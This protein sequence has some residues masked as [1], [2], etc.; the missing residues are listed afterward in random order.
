M[1]PLTIPHLAGNEWQYIKDCLDT[2]WVSSAGS[3]V[4][5]FEDAMASYCSAPRAVA[6][7]N[8]TAGLHLA[9]QVAGV[10]PGERVILPNVT[11]V[12]SAN[13]ISYA[14]AQPL[15]VDIDRATWQMD[16]DLLEDFLEHQTEPSAEGLRIKDSGTLIR[17]VMPVHVLGNMCD[18]HRLMA[19]ADKHGLTVIEDS[20]ESL[21]SYFD[22]R[23][24][25]TFGRMGVFSFNGNKVITTGGGGMIVT[26]EQETADRLKHLS[27]Q[28]KVDPE[29]YFHDTVGYNYRLV[30]VLAAMGVA[31]MEQL[32]GF[33]E[34]KQQIDGFYRAALAGIG[35]I[36]FQHIPNKVAPNHWLFTIWTSRA[37]AVLK[38]LAA[39]Q[40]GARPLWVPMNQLPMYADAPYV[41]NGDVSQEVY[42]GSVSL[43][44]SVGIGEKDL[45]RVVKVI[46][47]SY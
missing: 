44:S 34:K 11:F 32:P 18:M 13:A 12:A 5:K 27:T 19:L 39:A 28:A 6:C 24:S 17:V 7:M 45:E 33:L 40:I 42:R 46:R 25:G 8:G 22:G 31:Q 26:A 41:S 29:T 16:L 37:D 10:M 4:G 20:S 35:D 30:N 43:P 38:E 9:L 21:G 14:G 47:S 23:H 3:Y 2:G 36:Q 15:L 1:I